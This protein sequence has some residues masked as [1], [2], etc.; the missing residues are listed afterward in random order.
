MIL[1]KTE[2][3]RNY[4][5]ESEKDKF[6]CLSSRHAFTNWRDPLR[7]HMKDLVTGV[8]TMR[9]EHVG[10]TLCNHDIVCKGTNP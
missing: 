1:Y 4:L 3:N 7:W 9:G 5:R 2:R 8:R 10:L 6:D